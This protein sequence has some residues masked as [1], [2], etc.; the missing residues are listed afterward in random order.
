MFRQKKTFV[1]VLILQIFD[2]GYKNNRAGSPRSCALFNVWIKGI[3]IASESRRLSVN[4]SQVQAK[5][6]S[7]WNLQLKNQLENTSGVSQNHLSWRLVSVLWNGHEGFEV[8][9]TA[10]DKRRV[11]H[12]C[13]W[14][15]LIRPFITN[16]LILMELKYTIIQL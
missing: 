7:R 8:A 1:L 4:P 14:A 13:D 11:S 10:A 12:P 9:A 3:A 15:N 5:E 16:K 6:E 2:Q